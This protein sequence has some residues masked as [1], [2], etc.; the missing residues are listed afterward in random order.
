MILFLYG[1]DTFRSRQQLHKMVEKFR[2]DRD[3]EGLNVVTLDAEK[4]KPAAVLEQLFA[5]PFL[6]ERRMVVIE[7]L[8]TTKQKDLQTE[9]LRILKEQRVPEFNVVLFWDSVDTGKTKEVKELLAILSKEKF[10]QK[11]DL[12]IGSELAGWITTEVQERDGSIAREAALFLA[13]TVGGDMW[14]LNGLIDQLVA[15]VQSPAVTEGGKGEVHEISLADAR[16]FVNEKVDDNIFN[17]VDAIV[18]KQPRQVYAMIAEQYRK[19][20]DAQFIFAMITRQF[21]ILLQLRDLYNRQDNVPS[22]VLA[23]Q[24]GLHP[25]V[26]KKSLPLV[27]RYSLDELKQIY[28]ELLEIDI[29]TKTGQGDQSL[30]LDLFVG[31]VTAG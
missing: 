25:F 6:A 29:K 16:L 10:A 15:Y 1:K 7:Q 8:L 11:F 28:S 19:G 27:K 2:A 21:K 4:E 23:K 31:R 5:A 18:A 13:T 30:L 9:I 26:V 14:R 22:D 24:L 20:E 17:L 12:M 3:P